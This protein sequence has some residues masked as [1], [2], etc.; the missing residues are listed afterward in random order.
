MFIALSQR[1]TRYLNRISPEEIER[2]HALLAEG[3]SR[4]GILTGLTYGLGALFVPLPYVVALAILDFG[5]ERLGL[6]W[7]KGL[8]P[9][10]QPLRYGGTL[11]SVMTSQLSFTAMLAMAYQSDTPLAQAFSAG[12]MALS[13]LQ[14]ASIRVVHLPYA[15]VGL[16]AAFLVSLVAITVNWQMRSGPTGLFLSYLALAAAAYFIYMIVHA[17]HALHAGFA[18]ERVA[19]RAADQAK[20]RFLAQMSHELRTPLN[21]I[22]GLGYVELAQHHSPASDERL[23]LITNAARGLSVILD[24]ILDMSAIEAGVLPIRAKT[25]N[26]VAEI[27]AVVA[28]FQPLFQAQGLSLVLSLDPSLPTRVTMDTQRL[29][30]GLS[31]LISNAQ[32]HTTVGGLT[33]NAKI[34]D[35]NIL[36]I[37]LQDTGSGIPPSE[38]ER[39]FQPFQRGNSD[40]PGTGLGL[41]IT[42]SLA[43]SMGGDLVLLPS[44]IGAHFRLT[45]AFT[46]AAATARPEAKASLPPDLAGFQVLVVDDIATNRLVAKAHL[47]LLGVATDEASSGADAL[48]ILRKSIPDLVLLDMNMPQMDGI[49]TLKR[50]RALP[51]RAARV[52]VIAM[53]ADATDAHKRQYLA[54]GLDGHLAKPLTPEAVTEVLAR[55]LGKSV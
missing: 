29:R 53:T 44:D 27:N 25:G 45:L 1:L 40:K 46:Q 22:L 36:Q 13:L 42:R 39:V 50:I 26:P 16:G 11:L 14:L 32:K 12:V 8:N 3:Y 20:S 43:R 54:A 10:A 33:I 15:A 49:E 17:N 41:V 30:Q 34:Q 31:N 47:R 4:R 5:A 19:A 37:D 28:M 51:S 48:E 52:P 7:L 23:R 2:Q 35:G 21:A 9:L 55:F 24:D 6:V 38:A 18:R